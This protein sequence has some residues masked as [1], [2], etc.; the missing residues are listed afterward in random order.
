MGWANSSSSGCRMPTP[1]NSAIL[2]TGCCSD[3]TRSTDNA[4]AA[5]SK[6]ARSALNHHFDRAQ[7]GVARRDV[8]II[9][10]TSIAYRL[11]VLFQQL[12]FRFCMA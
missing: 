1:A 8:S 2:T 5:A 4:A 11:L 6:T 12:V 3:G 7:H 9:N 10:L